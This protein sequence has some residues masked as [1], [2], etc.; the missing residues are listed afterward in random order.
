MK[1]GKARRIVAFFLTIQFLFLLAMTHSES[2]HKL[3]HQD[4]GT[5]SHHCVVTTLQ[6]GQVD[7]PARAVDLVR[8]LSFPA[9]SVVVE[10]FSDSSVD[11]LLPPSCGPPAL[12]S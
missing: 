1:G 11:Y 12:L 6:G 5:R 8:T 4:A 3:F 2:L 7:A 9:A 10:F